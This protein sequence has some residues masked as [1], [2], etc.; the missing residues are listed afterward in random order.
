MPQT[1]SGRGLRQIY[2]DIWVAYVTH[3]EVS[4]HPAPLISCDV[5]NQLENLIFTLLR[6]TEKQGN[7][8]TVILK[9]AQTED[10]HFSCFFCSSRCT[11]GPKVVSIEA[12][13]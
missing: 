8:Y 1:I 7:V 13:S 5:Y 4:W 12:S 6:R 2:R 11:G 10:F 9:I 3:A